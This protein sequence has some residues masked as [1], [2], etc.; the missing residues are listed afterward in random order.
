ME[1]DIIDYKI[2]MKR[3]QL[4]ET[5]N[6]NKPFYKALVLI[7]N[8]LVKLIVIAFY[9]ILYPIYCLVDLIGKISN[10]SRQLNDYLEIHRKKGKIGMR[11]SPA[12]N[13]FRRVNKTKN[14][15][16]LLNGFIEGLEAISE[17][18][19]EIF[20]S[21]DI[22][23]IK[24]STHKSIYNRFER[25]EKISPNICTVNIAVDNQGNYKMSYV[26]EKI[27]M[28]SFIDLVTM[29]PVEIG[30]ILEKSE[31]AIIRIDVANIGK[32][33]DMLRHRRKYIKSE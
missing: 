31:K 13:S 15:T 29:D 22:K 30:K 17:N 4:M 6:K 8:K 11:M 26:K 32:V 2:I 33:A 9:I 14:T 24:F 25:I 1:C 28:N 3:G 7:Q 10:S 23:E 16:L 12:V 19:D 20:L 18:S 5:P 27:F 21:K